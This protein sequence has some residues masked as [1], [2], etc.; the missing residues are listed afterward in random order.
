MDDQLVDHQQFRRGLTE[1][2][3]LTH[4][5][6]PD[7][8]RLL[9]ATCP[10]VLD[11][12]APITPLDNTPDLPPPTDSAAAP[13]TERTTVRRTTVWLVVGWLVVGGC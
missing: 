2:L 5:A 6:Q 1:D 12:I 9:P 7:F 4:Y 3:G 10:A 11:G 8:T 13:S